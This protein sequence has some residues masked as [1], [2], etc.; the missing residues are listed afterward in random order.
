MMLTEF[1]KN[2]HSENFNTEK[3][4]APNRIYRAKEYNSLTEKY[5]RGV[6]Q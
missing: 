6:Q 1:G 4:K 5:T 2:E 3:N